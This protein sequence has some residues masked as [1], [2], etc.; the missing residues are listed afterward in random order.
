MFTE[1]LQK[2]RKTLKLSQDE[3][4]TQLGISY[5]AYTSYERGDRKPSIEVLS[6]LLEVV[7]VNLNWLISGQGEMFNAPKYNEVK[8]QLRSEVLKILKE[9]GLIQ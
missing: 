2:L 4:S 9:E 5:R 3:L 6:K 7:D 8:T 1:R